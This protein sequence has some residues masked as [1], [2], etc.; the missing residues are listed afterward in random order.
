MDSR[1]QFEEWASEFNLAIYNESFQN[2][3]REGWQASEARFKWPELVWE[4]GNFNSE[5]GTDEEFAE[6]I[7]GLVRY[8]NI[9]VTVST[10]KWAVVLNG[11]TI[12]MA[13]GREHAQSLAQRHWQE[14]GRKLYG[15][16]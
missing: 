7:E 5:S 2:G 12:G 6:P 11:K 16:Q 13:A 3:A 1:E 10:D 8:E 9:L 15:R 4:E 14:I